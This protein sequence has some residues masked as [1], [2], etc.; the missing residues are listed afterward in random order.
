MVSLFNGKSS[1]VG[2]LMQ[3]PSLKKNISGTIYTIDEE[4]KGEDFRFPKGINPKENVIEWLEFEVG[5]YDVAVQYI[6]HY[7]I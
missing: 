3:K 5:F 7:G 4:K 1:F 2:Y 6:S